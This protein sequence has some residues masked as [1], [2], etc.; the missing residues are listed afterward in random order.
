[1]KTE[2]KG[3]NWGI[4]SVK[5][6]V[7]PG[8]STHPPSPRREPLCR[9]G[10]VPAAE[11]QPRRR[12]IAAAVPG[13]PGV[14]REAPLPGTSE[15]RQAAADKEQR[16]IRGLQGTLAECGGQSCSG[17]VFG[18]A[19]KQEQIAKRREQVSVTGICFT[20][21][22]KRNQNLPGPVESIAQKDLKL[23]RIKKNSKDF[24]G[25]FFI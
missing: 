14:R 21:D 18:E 4:F 15:Q 25:N 12:R 7:M 19:K 23:Q 9:E 11:Q 24:A 6:T 8:S 22:L 13:S 2:R 10:P 5:M 16:R 3:V 17:K 20:K 1:M